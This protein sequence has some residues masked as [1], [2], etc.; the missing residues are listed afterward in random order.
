MRGQVV[1]VF[2]VEKSSIFFYITYQSND[3]SERTGQ[4]LNVGIRLYHT[5]DCHT[6]LPATA[7]FPHTPPSNKPLS[8][9]LLSIFLCTPDFVFCL[10]LCY[11]FIAYPTTYITCTF[12]LCYG[13]RIPLDRNLEV[14]ASSAGQKA[15]AGLRNNRYGGVV[16]CGGRTTSQTGRR[17]EM[18]GI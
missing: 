12:A 13:V 2:G 6:K 9:S 5:K 18:V 3:D 15:R 10:F 7:L 1:C 16:W 11:F 17:T 14:A 4:N 8:P